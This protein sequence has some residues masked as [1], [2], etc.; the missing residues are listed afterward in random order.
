VNPNSIEIQGTLQ[1]DSRLVLDEKPPLPPGRVRVTLQTVSGVESGAD[2]V[3]VLKRI[4]GAQ[5]ARGHVSR[6]REEIDA[7]IAA[8]RD[9]DEQ[10]LQAIERL[11]EER[12]WK[13]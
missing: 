6:T 2:V 12:R 3:A 4:R 7:A 8:M 10:R 1:A 5:Q 11:H 13:S 9:D